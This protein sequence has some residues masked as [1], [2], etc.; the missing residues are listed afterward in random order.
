MNKNNLPEELISKLGRPPLLTPEEREEIY[1]YRTQHGVAI[2]ALS[3]Y[4]CCSCSAISYA[5]KLMKE[6]HEGE[7]KRVWLTGG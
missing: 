1:I 5:L 2:R 6:K 7:E 4:Y 3:R